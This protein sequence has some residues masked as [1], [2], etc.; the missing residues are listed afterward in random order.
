MPTTQA[1][2]PIDDA[3]RTTEIRWFQEGMLPR[4]MTEWLTSDAL[5][6]Y[7]PR[8]TNVEDH[9][10]WTGRDDLSLKLRGSSLERKERLGRSRRRHA[11]AE[12]WVEHWKKDSRHKEPD[13]DVRSLVT[14]VHKQR[15]SLVFGEQDATVVPLEDTSGTPPCVVEI[16][17]IAV[18]G[19]RA[20]SLCLEANEGY[21]DLLPGLLAR[22]IESLPAMHR[23]A[24]NAEQ[25]RGYPAWLAIHGRQPRVPARQARAALPTW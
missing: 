20:W 3:L 11:G 4:E 1:G 19:H 9:Y 6:P 23:D 24:L 18:P 12:G 8:T 5:A 7:P 14:L 2:D 13:D 16:V 22:V 21:D 17:A 15:H 10:L 25:S